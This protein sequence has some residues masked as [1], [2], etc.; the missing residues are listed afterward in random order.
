[1]KITALI[2]GI[3]PPIRLEWL[4]NNVDYLDA[5]NFP[6]EKKIIAIDEF[7]GYQMPKNLKEYFESNGWEVL[8]DTH[9]SRS[10]TMDHA[11]SIINTEYVFYNEDDVL[12]KMPKLEDLE[13]VFNTKI[14]NKECG[15]IS[16]TL[17]GTQFDPSI[18]D[19]EFKFIGDLK[20]M[21][22]NTI[23]QNE[24]YRIFK[25]DFKFANAWFFEFP[26]LIIRTDLFK[27]CHE[28]AKR[29]GGQVEQALTTSF[30]EDG[31][32]EKYYKCSVAKLNALEY[33]KINPMSVNTECRLLTNLDVNQGN[34]PLGGNHNY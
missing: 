1:M 9:M 19:G 23:L 28:G 33:L 31:F 32:K 27:R 20:Y 13:K 8:V 5:Q 14:D 15:M 22:D 6:F 17:G 24:E 34:S 10:K 16:M 12:S 30:M 29:R 4:K 25:R 7:H 18:D 3:C 26:G 2:L 11:F 21:N